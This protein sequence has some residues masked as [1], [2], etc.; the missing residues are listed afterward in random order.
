MA[1]STE[2]RFVVI[3]HNLMT[4]ARMN[5]FFSMTMGARV[6]QLVTIDLQTAEQIRDI[7]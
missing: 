6:S 5:R 2:T 4:I 3:T 7:G 1:K